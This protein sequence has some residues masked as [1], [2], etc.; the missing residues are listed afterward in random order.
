MIPGLVIGAC[1]LA[2]DVIALAIPI[3]VILGL[4]MVWKK[5]VGYCAIFLTGAMGIV[6]SVLGLVYRIN[7]IGPKRGDGTW[8]QAAVNLTTIVELCLSIIISCAPFAVGY[9]RR[10][11]RNGSLLSSVRSVYRLRRWDRSHSP[12]PVDMPTVRS[13]R[14]SSATGSER[15][16]E[17]FRAGCRASWC[18]E[19]DSRSFD[20][21]VEL[22]DAVAPGETS[23]SHLPYHTMRSDVRH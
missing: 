11:F 17:V 1:N 13:S 4:H 10:V 3:P 20:T 23:Q 22:A 16:L 12:P 8:W 15:E 9:W 18:L 14:M 21:G 19:R 2:T 6:V 5:K 7:L